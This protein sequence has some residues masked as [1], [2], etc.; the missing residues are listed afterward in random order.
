VLG[1]DAKI[2]VLP[3]APARITGWGQPDH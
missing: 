1:R 3:R 2:A